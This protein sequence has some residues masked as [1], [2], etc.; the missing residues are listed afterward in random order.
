[1]VVIAVILTDLLAT[2]FE[3]STSVLRGVNI[4]APSGGT[5]VP[6]GISA[7]MR[8]TII[9]LVAHAVEEAFIETLAPLLEHALPPGISLDYVFEPVLE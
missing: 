2:C 6:H 3:N 7:H 1:M 9:A 4:M 8:P 5:L